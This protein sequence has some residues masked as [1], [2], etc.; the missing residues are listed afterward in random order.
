MWPPIP[1]TLLLASETIT[2]AFQRTWFW[3]SVSKPI[4]P[5]YGGCWSTEIEFRYGVRD[6]GAMGIPRALA[7]D[8]SSCKS[9][10]A[11]D[12]PWEAV[13]V[14]SASSH[15]SVSSSSGSGNVCRGSGE[16]MVSL[17]RRT[18]FQKRGVFSMGRLASMRRL[19][20]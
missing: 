10:R 1:S 5:G 3:I 19:S 16:D 4:L 9:N 13:R 20:Y 12:S 18:I 2:A 17:P 11:L 14:L 6:V 7:S 15:S 8:I